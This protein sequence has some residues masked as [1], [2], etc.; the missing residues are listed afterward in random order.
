MTLPTTYTEVSSFHSALKAAIGIVAFPAAKIQVV[1]G[2]PGLTE[3]SCPPRVVMFPIS[4]TFGPGT[5]LRH[6]DHPTIP[7]MLLEQKCRWELHLF[8]SSR[9]MCKAL[10]SIV[11]TAINRIRYGLGNWYPV[12]GRFVKH[13]VAHGEIYQYILTIELLV[14]LHE[15]TMTAETILLYPETYTGEV[16]YQ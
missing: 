15:T 16:D 11:C 1:L 4:D 5:Q 10:S 7:N 6:P 2:E 14:P 8:G 9:D 3:N 13:E 12:D